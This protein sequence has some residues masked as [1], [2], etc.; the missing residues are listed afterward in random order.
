MALTMTKRPPSKA[1]PRRPR[2]D[3]R[4]CPILERTAD[5]DVVGRC[6]FYIGGLQKCPRHGDV[7]A[8]CAHF[9]RTGK[10]TPEN[11]E[12]RF[13]ASRAEQIRAA[14]ADGWTPPRSRP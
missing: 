2:T 6:W 3:I 10:L 9:A 5:G 12:E 13:A 14:R 4:N 11:L 8:A 1:P 7:S